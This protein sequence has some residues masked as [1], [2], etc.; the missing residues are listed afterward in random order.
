MK[1][2]QIP[3][4]GEKMNEKCIEK[5]DLGA[6]H[7]VRLGNLEKELWKVGWIPRVR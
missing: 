7:F 3:V 6:A 5:Y 2:C 1:V 4:W